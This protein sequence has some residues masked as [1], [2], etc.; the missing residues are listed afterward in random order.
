LALTAPAGHAQEEEQSQGEQ[1]TR[2][3]PAMREKV[4]TRLAEAQECSEMD[5]LACA[6]RLLDQVRA[7]T[8]LTPYETAQMWN[9]YAFIY[10]SQDNYREAITAYENVLKQPELPVA[11]ETQTMYALAQMYVQQEQYQDALNMLNRWFAV[12]ENPQPEPYYLKAT[13][14]YQLQQYREGLEPIQA[15]IRL[16][17]QA[18]KMPQEGW[19]QLL[20]VFYFELEDFPNVIKTL[21]TLAE[22]W[23][24]K[25]Y[26]VQLAGI[27]G[28][29]GQDQNQLALYEAAYEAGWLT[30]GTELVTLAQMLLQADIPYKAAKILDEGIDAGTIESNQQNWRTLAQAWQLAQ[31][32]AEALPALTR[33]AS[34]ADDGE[35]Y[36]RLAQS[37]ANLAQHEECVEAARNGLRKGGLNRTDQA[38]VVLG[39]CLVELKEYNDARTA[40]QAAARDERSRRT[41][42]Q[43]LQYIDS[44]VARERE[45]AAAM[46]RG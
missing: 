31:E 30:R 39:S 46:R 7:M 36:V 37:H 27:Y 19:Y 41:A 44:E 33:A 35:V 42:Q 26:L 14:H 22:N 29:E 15:A 2:R 4:Y 9:F 21:T 12:A 45:I 16:A 24:K 1:Q 28:Q 5:D 10:Y 3:T 23:P 38:N 20:N 6:R 13:I 25:D 18:S 40:F 34:L 17:E 8:D 32:D 11:L 43:F